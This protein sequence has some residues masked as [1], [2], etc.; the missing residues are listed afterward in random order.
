MRCTWRCLGTRDGRFTQ[1]DGRLIPFVDISEFRKVLTSE[2]SNRQVSKDL[3]VEWY[4]KFIRKILNKCTVKR[5]ATVARYKEIEEVKQECII[6][7]Q[8]LLPAQRTR[9]KIEDIIASIHEGYVRRKK[10]L[11]SLIL[12]AKQES[13][14]ELCA[15]LENDVCG[16]GYRVAT[17]CPRSHQCSI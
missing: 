9:G 16:Q 13:W 4:T 11:K 7:R 14:K 2:I 5:K 15:N 12:T 3:L 10:T 1:A 6:E 17:R 8:Q